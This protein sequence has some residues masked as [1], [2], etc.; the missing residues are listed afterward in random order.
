MPQLPESV[1]KGKLTGRLPSLTTK[2]PHI[3]PEYVPEDVKECF[4]IWEV[5]DWHEKP[6][7]P[8]LVKRITDTCVVVLAGWDLSDIERMLM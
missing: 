1:T 6:K 5:T 8:L 2:I 7:D 4:I 3:P